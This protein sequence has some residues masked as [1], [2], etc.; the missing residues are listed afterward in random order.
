MDTV[1]YP[2]TN[3]SDFVSKYLVSLKV[4]TSS[5]PSWASGYP[6]Q[7]T[8]TVLI[9]DDS[10]REHHRIVGFLPPKEFVPA[11]MLGIAKAQVQM[12]QSAKAKAMLNWM[13]QVHGMSQA[14][15]DARDLLACPCPDTSGTTKIHL[16]NNGGGLY[17]LE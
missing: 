13:L 11:L 1:T 9:L 4:N 6:I 5:G 2:D 3:T 10:G 15:R 16:S 14:A 7:Y 17:E 8:P 12:G